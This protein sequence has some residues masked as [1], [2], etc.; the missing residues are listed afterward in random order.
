MQISEKQ[1]FLIPEA[2]SEH[3]CSLVRGV[4]AFIREERGN[5]LIMQQNMEMIKRKAARFDM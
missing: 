5:L 4:D 3:D 1:Q 2:L